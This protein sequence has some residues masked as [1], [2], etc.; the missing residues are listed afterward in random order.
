MS[1]ELRWNNR[2]TEREAKVVE[3]RVEDMYQLVVVD[4]HRGMGTWEWECEW[5]LPRIGILR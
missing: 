4:G 2:V 5:E 1:K 3:S